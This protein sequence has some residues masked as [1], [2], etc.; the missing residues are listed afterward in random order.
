MRRPGHAAILAM[1]VGLFAIACGQTTATAASATPTAVAATSAPAS[2]SHAPIAAPSPSPPD[3][4]EQPS[5]SPTSF[6][7][8]LYG[9]TVALPGGW[10][11]HPAT[12]FAGDPASTDETANDAI[13][14]PGT[15]TTIGILAWGLGTSTYAA[16]TKAYHAEQLADD[17]SGCDGGDPSTWASIPIGT[18]MGHL[19]QRCNAAIAIV[20]IGRRVY[21]FSWE[22]DTFD[23][24]RHLAESAFK[25]F[26]LGVQLPAPKVA[27]SP[28]PPWTP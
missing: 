2:P 15:D 19:Q 28:L 20:P 3:A 22:H 21:M 12:L 8:P 10:A 16:W 11:V 6:T 18:T 24:S 4:V 1:A 7:S 26:L 5:S 25:T 27:A 14:V 17:P 13:R 23:S 9:Y